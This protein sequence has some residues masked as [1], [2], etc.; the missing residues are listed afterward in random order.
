MSEVMS[1]GQVQ[2]LCQSWLASLRGRSPTT[3]GV[4]SSFG[5][6][7]SDRKSAGSPFI[8]VLLPLHEVISRR[9]AGAKRVPVGS[10]SDWFFG[11]QRHNICSL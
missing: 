9:S 10:G 3:D 1:A 8:S 11:P 2:L 7:A 4:W 6:E 5:A